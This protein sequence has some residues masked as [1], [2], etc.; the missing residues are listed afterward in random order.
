MNLPPPKKKLPPPK[1]PV[2]KHVF[3]K[4][5]FGKFTICTRATGLVVGSRLNR[6]KGAQPDK[7]IDLTPAEARIAVREWDEF[8]EENL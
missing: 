5:L 1:A 3:A 8:I 2:G 4:L 7:Y 6:G